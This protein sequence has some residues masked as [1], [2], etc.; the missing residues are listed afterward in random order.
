MP[1]YFCLWAIKYPN[2]TVGHHGVFC[3]FC[4]SVGRI[5][6]GFK[7]KLH[8]DIFPLFL[9]DP[10]LG[11][12]VWRVTLDSQDAGGPY[13]IMASSKVGN[14][15]SS[16]SLEDVLFGDVWVCSGQS[17]MEFTVTQVIL[18]SCLLQ[19]CRLYRC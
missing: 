11:S 14:T 10:A 15:T 17:N 4:Y 12:G 1:G 18:W 2:F 3:G 16:V 7:L 9:L 13:T 8:R 6:D 19:H 5:L